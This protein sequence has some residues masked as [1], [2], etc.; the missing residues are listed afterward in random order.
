M[1][2]GIAGK[3]A[4]KKSEKRQR[5]KLK[6]IRFLDEEFNTAAAKAS[7]AGMSFGAYVRAAATGDAGPRAQ[8]RMPV[9]AELLRR[10]LGEHGRV[11]NNMNQIAFALNA[12]GERG[13][14]ADFRAA[15]DDWGHIRDLM[16][17]ALGKDP[18]PPHDR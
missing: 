4:R 1:D 7:A 13:L 11:G 9:D 10:L 12:H 8:R 14:E 16:L 5:G 6:A 3:T 2:G 18:R 15:L 17:Q